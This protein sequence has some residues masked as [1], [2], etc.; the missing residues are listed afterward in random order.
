VTASGTLVGLSVTDAQPSPAPA[1]A[2]APASATKPII[3]NGAALQ[4]RDHASGQQ[5]SNTVQTTGDE[6]IAPTIDTVA[7]DSLI[8]FIGKPQTATSL[9]QQKQVFRDIRQYL[10]LPMRLT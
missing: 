3:H 7:A 1:P 4:A 2:P 8:D 9:N 6:T 10:D 5:P